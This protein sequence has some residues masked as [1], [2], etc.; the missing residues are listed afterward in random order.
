[1]CVRACFGGVVLVVVFDDGCD[2]WNERT[3]SRVRL[4]VSIHLRVN[5]RA[6][7]FWWRCVGGGFR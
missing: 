1:M 3:E 2:G 4:L 5:V 6:C 7:V